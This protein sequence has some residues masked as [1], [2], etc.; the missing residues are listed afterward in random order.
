MSRLDGVI[1]MLLRGVEGAFRVQ[2]PL[3]T[4]L[5]DQ[6][7]MTLPTV[8]GLRPKSRFGERTFGVIPVISGCSKLSVLFC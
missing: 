6:Y 8:L 7:G 4:W 5:K 1:L 2:V 3:L